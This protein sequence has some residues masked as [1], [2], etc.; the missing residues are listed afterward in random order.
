VKNSVLDRATVALLIIIGVALPADA[1]AYVDPNTG[2]LL[3]QLIAPLL[4]ALAAAWAFLRHQ[5]RQLGQRI[6]R[7]LKSLIPPRG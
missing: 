1:F 5:I 3:F 4:L 7:A 6:V 2:G